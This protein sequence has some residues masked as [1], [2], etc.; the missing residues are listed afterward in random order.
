MSFFA[1]P[2]A[3]RVG[4]SATSLCEAH[5][6]LVADGL[7]SAAYRRWPDPTP[8]ALSYVTGPATPQD[9]LAIARWRLHSQH[10]A[11]TPAID[12][13]AV[14]RR[15]L[16]V[17]AENHAQ[18]SWAVGARCH[19]PDAALF[20]RLY[21]DGA[22]LR[23]HLLRPTWHF[24]LPDD[25]GWLLDLSRPR[26]LRG[27]ERQLEQEGITH[28][29]WERA[30]TVIATALTGQQLTRAELANHLAD[31]GF[32]FSGH[33]L[34]LVAGLTEVHGLVCSG[35]TRDSQHTYAL[36]TERVPKTRRLEP[37]A[38]RAELVA[39]Y[40][41]GH[42]PVTERDVAYWATMTLRDVR[43]GLADIADRLS[44][45]ELD[46]DTFWH[47]TGA[48]DGS[49]I[50]PRAHLLQILDEYYRGYQHTRGLL[51]IAGQMVA[52]RED[53]IG[54]AIIDSQLVGGMN[55]TIGREYVTFDIRPLRDLTDDETVAIHDAAARYGHF[56]N[57]TPRLTFSNTR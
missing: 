47:T 3:S 2:F 15:L 38:A 12:A 23:T 29:L 8:I 20:V 34:M 4:A 30:A 16:A 18:A 28:A 39:R 11:G 25:I 7:R 37:D 50:E 55:R 56:L 6:C 40:V 17:Q 21:N 54:M 57:R 24:V 45:F 1:R 32:N 53:S 14:V 43:V 51:D 5:G 49:T 35:P 27:W 33:A 48:P 41:A 42:G 31:A 22:I 36:F 52:G 13:V 19:T 44:S 9:Q 10:L 46:G 26:L